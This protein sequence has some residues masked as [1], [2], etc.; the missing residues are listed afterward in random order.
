[1]GETRNAYKISVGRPE[2]KGQR[3]RPRRRWEDDIR[4]Y[5]RE[6]GW[7]VGDWIHLAQDKDRYRALVNTVMNF[8]VP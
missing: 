3:G 1:V 6:M 7:E 5:L 2:R 8:R 4:M